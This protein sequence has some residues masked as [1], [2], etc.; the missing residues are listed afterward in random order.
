METIL[1]PLVVIVLLAAYA[2]LVAAEFALDKARGFRIEVQADQCSAPAM[3]TVGIWKNL[4]VDIHS[5]QFMQRLSRMPMVD[6]WVADGGYLMTVNS[7]HDQ[8]VGR[9]S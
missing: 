7:L 4:S 6:G 3:L 8:R 2:F 9:V 1:N 5:G